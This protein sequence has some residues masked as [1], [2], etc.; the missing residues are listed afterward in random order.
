MCRLILRDETGHVAFHRDRL[1]RSV[2]ARY[3]ALWAACFRALGFVAASVLWVSHAR[4]L[5]AL[6]ATRS[7]FYREVGVGLSR[8]VRQLRREA[9]RERAADRWL[10]YVPAEAPGC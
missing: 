3:G 4:G 1:A 2:R 10:R 8:F 5:R 9:R 6:G 7:E